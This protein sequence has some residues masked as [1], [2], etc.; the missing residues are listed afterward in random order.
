[1]FLNGLMKLIAII[2]SI[3]KS[4]QLHKTEIAVVGKACIQCYLVSFF[5]QFRIQLIQCVFILKATIS[6]FK[7]HFFSNTAIGIFQETSCLL[8]CVFLTFYFHGHF[9]CNCTKLLSI[10]I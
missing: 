6:N 4:S 5:Q 8:Q 9:T 7:E 3:V 1:M 10:Y 2:F